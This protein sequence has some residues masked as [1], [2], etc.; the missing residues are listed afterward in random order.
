MLH[1]VSAS[2]KAVDSGA[3]VVGA[4]LPESPGNM[5]IS[6][7][8]SRMYRAGA[9]G[10]FDTLAVHPYASSPDR[11]LAIAVGLRKLMDANGDPGARIWVSEIGWADNGPPSPFTVGERG[12]SEMIRRVLA[13][14]VSQADRLKIRGVIYFNW[15]D[16]PPYGDRPDFWG[17]HTGLYDIDGT[18]K[19]AL[20]AYTATV[21]ALVAR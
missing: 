6:E 14:F 7:F 10:A 5:P 12:Q 16:V 4:G 18:P 21:N 11:A 13:T 20:S 15:R 17:L 8:V 2:I 9:R 19:P 1:A 3:E